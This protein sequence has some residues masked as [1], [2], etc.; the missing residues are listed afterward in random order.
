MALIL[1]AVQMARESARRTTCR[2]NL[3]QIGLALH[4]F[5]SSHRVFPPG[6]DAHE[7][8]H[9][10]WATAVLPHLEQTAGYERYDYSHAWNHTVNVPVIKSNVPVFR[11]PSA[12]EKWSGKSDYGGNFGTTL[13][14]L[15]PGFSRGL[16]WESGVLL[17][18][19]MPYGDIFRKRPVRMADIR[20]GASNTI[21][22]VEDADRTAREGGRWGDG[23]NG[24]AHDNG[25]VNN[26]PSSEIHSRHP[27][28]AFVLMTDGSV[29]FVTESMDL[30]V[31]GAL[32]TRA[33]GE[34]TGP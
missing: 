24:V 17:V 23:H 22:V 26:S 13:T 12:V 7:D 28:G 10:S 11:C 21:I 2:N 15:E 3:R 9:H 14:G 4:N 29:R 34:V 27:G 8:H 25:P 18:V 19:R 20:D 6:R 31:L 1:P 5:E 16:G 32:C 33:G 30:D